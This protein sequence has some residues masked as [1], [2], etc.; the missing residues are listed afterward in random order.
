MPKTTPGLSSDQT[1]KRP[2][3]LLDLLRKRTLKEQEYEALRAW[4]ERYLRH[5]GKL[6]N[7]D[8]DDMFGAAVVDFLETADDLPRS[9]LEAEY[10]RAL[11]RHRKRGQRYYSRMLPDE[12]AQLH[13]APGDPDEGVN[14]MDRHKVVEKIKKAIPRVL[15]SMN[16]RYRD[17]ISEVWLDPSSTPSDKR[18][19]ADNKALQRAVQQFGSRLEDALVEERDGLEQQGKSD[20]IL[21]DAIKVVHHRLLE[22]LMGW[23][24]EH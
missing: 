6:S 9:E 18:S 8:I 2:V 15:D 7:E 5:Y 14:K 10:T 4:S 1:P 21:N 3:D 16:D 19:D 17:L 11:D 22:D 20:Q 12:K 24:D 13:A 23:E